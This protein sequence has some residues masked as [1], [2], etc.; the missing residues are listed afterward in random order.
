MMSTVIYD[1]TD[2]KFWDH[3]PDHVALRL[4]RPTHRHH[5]RVSQR[6]IQVQ[7]DP[8]A[9][10]WPVRIWCCCWVMAWA[11]SKSSQVGSG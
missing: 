3:R 4:L 11:R 1:P 8:V 6:P 7:L 10:V 9:Q 5:N 2:P